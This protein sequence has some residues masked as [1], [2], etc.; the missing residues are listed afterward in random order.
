MGVKLRGMC[1]KAW[2]VEPPE[3]GSFDHP[4]VMVVLWPLVNVRSMMVGSLTL[5]R[6]KNVNISGVFWTV[7][8]LFLTYC[9][10]AFTCSLLFLM[11]L[12]IRLSAVSSPYR[13]PWWLLKSPIMYTLGCRLCFWRKVLPSLLDGAYTLISSMGIPLL[14]TMT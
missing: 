6:G 9:T 12:S 1:V 10:I 8:S 11:L 2:S 4:C 7:S 13:I 14:S 3:P 5:P